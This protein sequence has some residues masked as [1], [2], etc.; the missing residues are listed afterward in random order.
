MKDFTE[1]PRHVTSYLDRALVHVAFTLL[2]KTS[3]FERF[4]SVESVTKAIKR[5]ASSRAQSRL[6]TKIDAEYKKLHDI[7]ISARAQRDLLRVAR[8]FPDNKIIFASLLRAAAYSDMPYKIAQYI[9]R[10]ATSAVLNDPEVKLLLLFQRIKNEHFSDAAVDFFHIPQSTISHD[11]ILLDIWRISAIHLIVKD[12]KS[13]FENFDPQSFAKLIEIQSHPDVAFDVLVNLFHKPISSEVFIHTLN[14]ISDLLFDKSHECFAVA[15]FFLMSCGLADRA[16]RLEEINKS[17]FAGR[18]HP[19]Y[20]KGKLS[21]I[22]V[23]QEQRFVSPADLAIASN[24]PVDWLWRKAKLEQTEI[25]S[26][27]RICSRVGPFTESSGSSTRLHI[28]VA[29][30]GQ[31]RFPSFTLPGIKNWIQD[32]FSSADEAVEISYGVSTWR[33]TGA[34]VIH[35]DD[36]IDNILPYFPAGF[37]SPLANMGLSKVSDCLPLF[38]KF[39]QIVLAKTSQISDHVDENELTRILES[40]IYSNIGNDQDFMLDIGS[41][42]AQFAPNNTSFLNQGRMIDRIGAF[43]DIIHQIDNSKLPISHVLFIRPD[44][45]NLSGSLRKFLDLFKSKRNWAI[46]DEDLLAQAIEGVGDRY[47]FADRA[48]VTHILAARDRIRKIFKEMP[49]DDQACS[50]ISG[51]QMLGTVLFENAV[52][53]RVVPR[54]EIHWDVFRINFR[55]ADCLRELRHDVERLSDGNIKQSLM[56]VMHELEITI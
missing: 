7:T 13:Y 33:N 32:D 45:Y 28:L 10:I 48:A 56:S 47:I 34:K 35:L 31:M 17:S 24:D 46:L 50:R 53:I 20:I 18:L 23:Y 39:L 2:T 4:G 5:I 11:T 6:L 22:G 21:P 42:I 52:D 15:Y 43:G 16:K 27:L 41:S 40:P 49:R 30:F 8:I 36:S 14:L 54:S 3:H 55:S 12:S 9:T 26:R 19:L 44:L 1:T 38:P 37:A 29:F 25:G 51:H